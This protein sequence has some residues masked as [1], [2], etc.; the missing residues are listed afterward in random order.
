MS[1]KTNV[2]SRFLEK[3]F[4]LPPVVPL[5]R[6]GGVIGGGGGPLRQSI[7]ARSLY[8]A[9]ERAFKLPRAKAVAIV[10]NS[11]GGSP[12]QAALIAQRLRELSEEKNLP[13]YAFCEDVAA[14]GGYWIACAADEV[15]A[16]ENS[17]VGSIGVVSAGFGFPGLLDKLGVE[18]RVHASGE[19]KAMLDPF[20]PEDPEDV[21]HLEAL[22]ED[23]HES[24]KSIV[25]ERRGERLKASEDKLFSG[26]FWTGKTSL[27][28]GLVDG[29][30]T[31]REV[32]RKR[33]GDRV[34]TPQVEAQRGWLRR[35]LP[36][37][38]LGDSQDAPARATAWASG[39][40]SA[41]E[42]RALWGRY[43]L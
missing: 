19:R 6:V 30:G 15:Y 24:F 3:A 22:Q 34:K 12:V 27:E 20:R 21:K 43:G 32:L 17:V 8:P 2:L 39:V 38:T 23:V 14:S 25:R 10:V 11:P 28:L 26:A 42:E 4:K 5:V 40:I 16:H 41:L 36:F 18:R 35:R 9:L 29:L 37:G 33:F 7:S 31:P 1:K 13:V